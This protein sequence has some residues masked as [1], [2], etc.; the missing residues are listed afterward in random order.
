MGFNNLST[1]KKIIFIACLFLI[2]K[3]TAQGNLQFNQVLTYTQ[4][5]SSSSGGIGGNEYSGPTY[6][7][8]TGKV[9]KVENCEVITY[10]ASS[11]SSTSAYNFLKINNVKAVRL[12]TSSLPD[13]EILLPIWFKSGDQIKVYSSNT[14]SFTGSFFISIIEFNIVP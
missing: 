13:D 9:W 4:Q 2:I 11:E 6:Q 5:F 12:K 7:V 10:Y 1:M 3:A 14:S 8:P